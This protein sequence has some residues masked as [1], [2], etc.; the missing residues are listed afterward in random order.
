[1]EAL[2]LRRPPFFAANPNLFEEMVESDFIVG[3][4]GSATVRRVGEGTSQRMARTVL[5][6][7]EVQMAVSKLDAAIGLARDVRVVRHHQDG[8]PGVVQFAKNLDDHG[9]V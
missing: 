1:M 5:R 7:V 9:L 6:R 3:G 4:S 2:C 8:V